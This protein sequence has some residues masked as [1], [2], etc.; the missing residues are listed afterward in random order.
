MSDIVTKLKIIPFP[1]VNLSP[2]T[3]NHVILRTPATIVT[4]HSSICVSLAIIEPLEDMETMGSPTLIKNNRLIVIMT[5]G[6]RVSKSHVI[7]LT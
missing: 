4:V 3:F 7:E 5:T 6:F 1:S 2:V